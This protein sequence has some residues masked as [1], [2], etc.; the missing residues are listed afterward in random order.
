MLSL[1]IRD[2]EQVLRDALGN[3]MPWTEIGEEH[4]PKP[5]GC[6]AILWIPGRGPITGGRQAI[7]QSQEGTPSNMNPAPIFQ[8][9]LACNA[10]VFAEN[11]KATEKLFGHLVAALQR[12]VPGRWTPTGE[13]WSMGWP[14]ATEEPSKTFESGTLCI[15]TFELRMAL[16]REPDTDLIDLDMSLE[17]E[18]ETEEFPQ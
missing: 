17:G 14:A 18:I 13:S 1:L 12:A 6:P 3:E 7:D 4:L 10:Y 16:V 2:T 9:N 8:R 15:V 5:G 11:F